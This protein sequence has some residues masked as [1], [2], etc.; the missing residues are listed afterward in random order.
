MKCQEKA[1]LGRFHSGFWRRGSDTHSL[2]ERTFRYENTPCDTPCA[3]RWFSS[4]GR[5]AIRRRGFL[6]LV[7]HIRGV[8]EREVTNQRVTAMAR[9]MLRS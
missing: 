5:G 4:E 9:I 7:N 1:A 8:A 2:R 6:Q 3:A